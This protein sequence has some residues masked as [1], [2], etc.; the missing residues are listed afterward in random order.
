[1]PAISTSDPNIERAG[2]GRGW[3]IQISL[4]LVTPS[5]IMIIAP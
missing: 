3:A 4:Q 1:M 5:T 2:D